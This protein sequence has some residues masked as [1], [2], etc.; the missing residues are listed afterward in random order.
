MPRKAHWVKLLLFA[1]L[2]SPFLVFVTLFVKNRT[3]VLFPT[4]EYGSG[5]FSQCIGYGLPFEFRE[6]ES[7]IDTSATHYHWGFFLL[8]MCLVAAVVLLLLHLMTRARWLEIEEA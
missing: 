8:N 6:V 7:F 5:S 3:L 2:T 1:F 4:H